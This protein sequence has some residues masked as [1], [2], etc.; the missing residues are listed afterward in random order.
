MSNKEA[1]AGLVGSV[2][3]PLQDLSSE[4]PTTI[5]AASSWRCSAAVLVGPLVECRG[6]K[7]I[8]MEACRFMRQDFGTSFLHEHDTCS[9]VSEKLAGI[10]AKR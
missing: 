9:V 5:S 6:T 10:Y 3:G 4:A 2:A 8:T 7:I 1:I